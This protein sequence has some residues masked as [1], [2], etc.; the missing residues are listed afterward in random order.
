MKL[1]GKSAGDIP[2]TKAITVEEIHETFFTEV[3]R[4]MEEVRDNNDPETK[5]LI[6]RSERLSKLGFASMPAVRE[7]RIK[8]T[9]AKNNQ[10]TLEAAR[11]FSA[12]YPYKFIT[13]KSVKKIC[14]KYGLIYGSVQLYIGEVPEKNL[15]QLENFSI[16]DEDRAYDCSHMI[17]GPVYKTSFNDAEEKR[18]NYHYGISK[19]GL[20]ICAP[21]SMFDM[22]RNEVKNYKLQEVPDPIV[23]Q[24][25]MY[26][27]E[28]YY[29]IV[30]A[31]GEEASDENVVNEKMN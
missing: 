17:G 14:E 4:I 13:E 30:T 9:E 28:S 20:E 23:L 6:E 31:W 12:K 16:A 15:E 29:L 26:K 27:D 8:V 2:D 1:F 11:Y 5:Q 10:K 3:D 21:L 18:Q 7:G 24:P 19:S 25:V 22:H